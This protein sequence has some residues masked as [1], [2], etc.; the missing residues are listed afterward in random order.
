MAK[1]TL[2]GGGGFNSLLGEIKGTAKERVQAKAASLNEKQKANPRV[3]RPTVRTDAAS[4]C[5]PG[6][7]GQR[8]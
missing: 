4:G 7:L 3:G 1:K 5:K 2:K 6:E 8:L